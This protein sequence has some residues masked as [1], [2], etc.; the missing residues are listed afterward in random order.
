MITLDIDLTYLSRYYNISTSSL[1]Q[2]RS[3]SITQIMQI[4]AAKGNAKAAEFL[5]RILS[6]PKELANLFQLINPNNRYLIL[7]HMNED[8]LMKVMEHLETKQFIIGL[9]SRS[10]CKIDD[11]FAS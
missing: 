9:K 11:V 4:E 2:Y 6:E 3:K 10:S 5:L 8:D 1:E 7:Q